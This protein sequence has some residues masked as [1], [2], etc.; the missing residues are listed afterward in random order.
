[1]RLFVAFDTSRQIKI[2]CSTRIVVT[3]LLSL[4]KGR[5]PLE[6]SSDWVTLRQAQDKFNDWGD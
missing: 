3:R 6:G 4:T 2:I 5:L 1:M